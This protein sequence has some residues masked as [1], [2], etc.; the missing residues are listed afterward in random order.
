MND[1]ILRWGGAERGLAYGPGEHLERF[2][3]S[4]VQVYVDQDEAAL[5]VDGNEVKAVLLSGEHLLQVLAADEDKGDLS[6]AE[7]A[8][9]LG[10]EDHDLPL[11]TRRVRWVR[12][13]D[14]LL[15]LNVGELGVHGLDTSLRVGDT[16]GICVEGACRLAVSD[17]ILLFSSFLR[18][19]EDLPMVDFE[20]ILS[21]I[22]KGSFEHAVRGLFA[23]VDDLPADP[24]ALGLHAARAMQT[25]LGAAGLR[26]E[27]IELTRLERP[28]HE[29]PATEPLATPSLQR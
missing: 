11:A 28:V 1:R 8:R 17:P 14:R 23:T 3:G 7:R 22:V 20:I 18:N 12:G 27:E 15:F 19:S 2:T 16:E 10:I 26:V 24:R 21:H 29:T 13:S 6:S 5:L 4:S 9:R 25:S